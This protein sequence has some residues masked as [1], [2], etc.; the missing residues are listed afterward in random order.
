[1]QLDLYLTRT[2]TN[3]LNPDI[4]TKA[5]L[6]ITE[7]A[8]LY[9]KKWKFS[10]KCTR[11][12]DPV[13]SQDGYRY[14]VKLR[15]Y[16]ESRRMPQADI[17]KKQ[18]ETVVERITRRATARG[19]AVEA[20]E[21]IEVDATNAGKTSSGSAVE[22]AVE[23]LRKQNNSTHQPAQHRRA[24]RFAAK[25]IIE[26]E[27][28]EVETP[29][30]IFPE[31]TVS[32]TSRYFADIYERE[33]HLRIVHSAV[34]TS[35]E[36]SGRVLSHVLLYGEPG[37][38][39][40]RLMECYKTWY[41]ADGKNPDLVAVVDGA[42]MTKAGL[43]TFLLDLYKLNRM[44]HVLVMD[45]IEKQDPKNLLGLL[46]VMGSGA[47]TRLNARTGHIRVPVNFT[48]VG[49][50]NDEELLKQF[51]KGALYSRFT[52]KLYCPPPSREIALLILAKTAR[53]MGIVNQADAER[54]AEAA[55]E[56]GWDILEQRDI[57]ALKGHLDGRERLLSG[58]WQAD[59]IAMERLKRNR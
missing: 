50:C 45:E 2:T 54:L 3:K 1:M 48:V 28:I 22:V 47:L 31:L 36:S 13:E 32:V 41:E 35:M 25:T 29:P 23:N 53:E 9:A 58:E 15:V 57:R 21:V 51:A 55:L 11:L 4:A 19:W 10:A 49:I 5:L 16:K 38:C 46:N 24:D 42:T 56:L 30:F 12:K 7:A 14:R 6:W 34:K 44:P 59:Q 8:F 40:T 33:P 18:I 43:E 39:K 17:L 27:P 20:G 37:A 52:H 26:V